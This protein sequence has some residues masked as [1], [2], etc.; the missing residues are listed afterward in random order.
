MGNSKEVVLVPTFR[1]NEYL[2][3][4]L[5]SIRA[6]DRKIKIMCFSDRGEDNPELRSVCR[7][8][9]AGLRITPMHKYWGNSYAVLEALRWS[10]ECG[11]DLTI[12]S[13][14]DVI[15][16]PG[17]LDWHR[18]MHS[19][20]E[21]IFAACGWVFNTHAP[22]ND[23]NYFV[24]WLYSPNYS[25][26]REKLRQVT[27]HANPLY[28]NGMRD[29]VMKH[30]ANSPL[31]KNCGEST[32]FYEQ[33]AVV[34]FCIER[35]KAQVAWCRTAKV[36]HIGAFGYNRTTGPEFVG[37]LEDRIRQVK[38]LHADHYWRAELFGRDRVER[39][40]GHVLPPRVNKFRVTM[41][42]GW[43]TTVQ[44]ELSLQR[45]GNRLN[46]APIEEGTIFEQI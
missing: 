22:I 38:E 25:I 30:F 39:E 44:T 27:A 28:Y 40:I 10:V 1:R 36:D 37:T 26:R 16:H 23:S 4:A 31:L 43:S 11:F 8:W 20:F 7:Q 21:D 32:N 34:Q 42:G 14:D 12:Y 15:H 41:P 9:N 35:D 5:E 24:P 17:C 2:W 19:N 13:E 45:L 46:S 18:E 29:Y 33:D 3:C 6:Q